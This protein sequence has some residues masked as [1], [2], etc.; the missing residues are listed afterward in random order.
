MAIEAV[1]T[2]RMMWSFFDPLEKGLRVT[3]PSKKEMQLIKT[4]RV[5]PGGY[6][7]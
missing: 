6:K 1:Q 3:I 5:Y 4:L 7:Y 2:R